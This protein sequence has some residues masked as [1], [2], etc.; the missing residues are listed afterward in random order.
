MHYKDFIKR[1]SDW[2]PS[3]E[4]IPVD[5]RGPTSFKFNLSVRTANNGYRREILDFLAKSG[6][7]IATGQTLTQAD[8]SEA[9]FLYIKG[10]PDS[11]SQPDSYMHPNQSRGFFHPPTNRIS[12]S[13]YHIKYPDID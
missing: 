13:Q 12:I 2:Y 5:T 9:F 4:R 11:A 10:R 3:E 1:F 6:V 7:R 8:P